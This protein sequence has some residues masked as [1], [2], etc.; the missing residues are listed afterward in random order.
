MDGHGVVVGFGFQN[1][2]GRLAAQLQADVLHA[3][4]GALAHGDAAGGRAGEGN[5]GNQRVRGERIAHF[6]AAASDE[7]EDALREAGFFKGIGQ[8]IG[9]ERRVLTGL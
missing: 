3:F 2:I 4:E 9:G 6:A 5:H 1:H 8:E 7:I